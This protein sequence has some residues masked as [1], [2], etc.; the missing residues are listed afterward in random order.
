MLWMKMGREQNTV[1]SMS[2]W[3]FLR[4]AL[5]EDKVSLPSRVAGHVIT[6][7]KHDSVLCFVVFLRYYNGNDERGTE[8]CLWL[9][10]VPESRSNR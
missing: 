4:S 7:V 9:Q 2:C 5:H 6:I 10:V 1:V 8:V 3:E